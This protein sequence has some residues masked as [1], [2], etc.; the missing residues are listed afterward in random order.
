MRRHF[1]KSWTH[2]YKA[3]KDGRK[4]HDLRSDDRNYQVGDICVLQE[5]DNIEGR[6]TGNEIE[7]EITYIT[8]RSVPCAFSSAVLPAGYSILSLKV[9]A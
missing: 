1:I 5:Y 3:I 6:Y 2:F 4:L 9:A 7:A 8:N